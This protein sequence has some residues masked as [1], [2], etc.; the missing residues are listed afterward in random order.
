MQMT[1]KKGAQ[2]DK[3]FTTIRIKRTTLKELEKIAAFLTIQRGEKQDLSQA[4]DYAAATAS[5]MTEI[6]PKKQAART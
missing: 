4:A 6:L 1:P 2:M 5:K 3:E